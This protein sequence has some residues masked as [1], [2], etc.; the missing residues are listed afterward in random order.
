MH[1]ASPGPV[2]KRRPARSVTVRELRQ[3]QIRFLQQQCRARRGCLPDAS[4]VEHHCRI[5]ADANACA[6]NA[7]VMPPPTIATA[8]S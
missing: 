8:V 4:A 6:T 7:P 2:A 5:P 3:L 1:K